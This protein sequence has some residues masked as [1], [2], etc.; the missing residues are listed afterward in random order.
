MSN[1]DYAKNQIKYL[2]EL[3]FTK[4][5]QRQAQIAELYKKKYEKLLTYQRICE[6][7]GI[8]DDNLRRRFK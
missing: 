1:A 8:Y 6:E 4:N 3:P 5:E 7:K 2:K